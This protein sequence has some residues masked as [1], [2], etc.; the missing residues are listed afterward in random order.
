MPKG[1]MRPISPDEENTPPDFTQKVIYVWESFWDAIGLVPEKMEKREGEL[2]LSRLSNAVHY[3][4]HDQ[5]KGNPTGV[6]KTLINFT[7]SG[8]EKQKLKRLFHDLNA[9]AF[10]LEAGLPMDTPVDDLQSLLDD[11]YCPNPIQT[12]RKYI[13]KALELAEKN[14]PTEK[15]KRIT[16]Q[17]REREFA[18]ELALLWESA[19]GKLPAGPSWNDDKNVREDNMFS[20]MIK[21]AVKE[22]GGNIATET[23]HATLVDLRKTRP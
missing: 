8:R 5:T 16:F 15:G 21:E 14:W 10:L 11:D 20:A 23:I 18:E 2:F 1:Y 22:L 13:G 7:K 4:V 12:I 17:S 9:K 3:F 6:K 19:T